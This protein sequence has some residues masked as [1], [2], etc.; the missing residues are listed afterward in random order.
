[1]RV[2]SGLIVLAAITGCD[3]Q[4]TVREMCEQHPT[5]CEDLNTDSHCRVERADVIF[6]RVAEAQAP[7]LDNKYNLLKAFETYSKC[8]NLAKQIEH[9]KLKEK[10]ASRYVGFNTAQKEMKRLLDETKGSNHPGLLYFHWSRNND[11]SAI[12]KLLAMEND[13]KVVDSQDAQFY[14][15]SYYMKVDTDKTLYHLYRNLE[16]NKPDTEPNQEVLTSL[17]NIHYQR[18]DYNLAYTF[19]R[20]A[21]LAGIENI[22]YTAL[23]SYTKEAGHDID[24]LDDLAQTTY[25]QIT[26]GTFHSPRS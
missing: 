4:P 23:T 9:I 6:D 7:T 17:V 15:A 3:S 12:V 20:I 16:L 18:H 24:R 5:M 22:D 19:A 2:L 8:V 11:Q 13:P 14:L 26:S 25:E 1:M 10:T 21:T